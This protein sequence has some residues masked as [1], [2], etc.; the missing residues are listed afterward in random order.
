MS[1]RTARLAWLTGLG[2]LLFVP[3]VLRVVSWER[4]GFWT[5]VTIITGLLAT[6][7]IVA[8]ALLPSRLKTVTRAFGA[9]AVLGMHRTLGLVSVA[10][11]AAHLVAIVADNPANVWLFLPGVAPARA[12]C[13]LLGVAAVCALAGLATGRA[14]RRYETWRWWHVGLAI[15]VLGGTAGHV[16]LLQH[17]VV[18]PVFGT[19]LGGLAGVLF[20][21]LGYRWAVRPFDPRDRFVVEEVRRENEGVSTVLLRSADPRA[22]VHF[23]PGQFAWLRMA[24]SPFTE[25]HPFTI[26]SAAQDGTRPTFTIRHRGDWTESRLELLRPGDVVW[27]DG[28]HGGL[29]PGEHSTGFVLIAGGVGITPMMSM[30]RTLARRADARPIRLILADRPGERLFRDELTLLQT[31]LRMEVTETRRAP[32]TAEWL[33]STLPGPFRR[34]QLDYFVCGS[35][36]LVTDTTGALAELGI[37]ERRVHTELF[38]VA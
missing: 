10:L 9:E 15:T 5:E 1:P 28:P 17:L 11:L 6:S 24:P 4:T 34:E 36:R 25:E 2:A 32:I 3:V 19:F 37:P 13:G 30:V 33:A 12:V 22:V 21:V 18:D 23:D 16:I 26:S 14:R 8:A 27:L 7:T 20:A 38:D 31:Q 35:P 29:T